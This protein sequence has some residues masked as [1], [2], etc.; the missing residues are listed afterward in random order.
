MRPH[1]GTVSLAERALDEAIE[2]GLTPAELRAL[3]R[4]RT[5]VDLIPP[6]PGESPAAYADRATS[7]L[8]VRYL[9]G[10]AGEVP[11]SD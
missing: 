8:L 11:P 4:G 6:L 5:V 2:A 9:A 10:D 3:L 7:E 1:D